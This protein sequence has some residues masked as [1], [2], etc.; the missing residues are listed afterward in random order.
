MQYLVLIGLLTLFAQGTRATEQQNDET[1]SNSST[2][3]KILDE[4]LK[5]IFDDIQPEFDIFPDSSIPKADQENTL[6]NL[7]VVDQSNS[8][9]T[10]IS[11]G[12]FLNCI[13][14]NNMATVHL[15]NDTELIQLLVP[16]PKIGSEKNAPGQCIAV[17]FYSKNCPFSSIAAPHFNALPRAFPNIKMVAI[18]AM[19]YHLFNTQ[20]GIVGVPTL[21]LFHNG[22]PMVRYNGSN[23]NLESFSK[24]ITRHTGMNAV[25]NSVVTSQDFAG[26]VVSSPSKESDMFLVISWFFII[27][28]SCYYFSKSKM[29]KW[30]VETI[31]RNWRESEQH[32]HP[33]VD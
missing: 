10:N 22:R 1:S 9:S 11:S 21:L 12:K 19:R 30:V 8:T 7:T 25:E 5:P 32:A 20:N 27:V 6:A 14:T 23:Y 24:F 33:H 13:K 26:P 2:D 16:D 18:N 15:V 31:Q 4:S 3:K 29:W 17:L 28:C